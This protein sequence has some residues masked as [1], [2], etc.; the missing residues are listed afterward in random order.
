MVLFHSAFVALKAR[1]HLTVKPNPDD[2]KLSG[3][4]VKF[5]GCVAPLPFKGWVKTFTDDK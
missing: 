1:C 3:E 5:K 2:Y 4:V